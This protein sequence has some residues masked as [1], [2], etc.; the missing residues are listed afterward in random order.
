MPSYSAHVL[1]HSLLAEKVLRAQVF[2]AMRKAFTVA[3]RMPEK[4]LIKT[5]EILGLTITSILSSL[6]SLSFNCFESFST[7]KRN[8]FLLIGI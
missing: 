1:S 6:L 8:F 4:I 5:D 7:A 3:Q 2:N